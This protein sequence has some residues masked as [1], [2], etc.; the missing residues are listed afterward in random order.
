MGRDDGEDEESP[1][2]GLL[3]GIT[4]W[5]IRVLCDNPMDG[6]RGYTPQQVG[7]MTVD[8][9]MM[10][11]ADKKVL[12]GKRTRSITPMVASTMASEEGLIRGRDRDGNPI[13]GKFRGVSK[14][15]ELMNAERNQV[16]AKRRRKKR[17]R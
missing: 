15:R 4:C 17:K 8:Q 5:H 2:V 13:I 1:D 11:M 3:C 10:L 9:I 6:G 16:D 12:L 7:E 14:A